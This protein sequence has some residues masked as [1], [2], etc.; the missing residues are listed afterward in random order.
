MMSVLAGAT[1]RPVDL[2]DLRCVG[3]PLLGEI[4][5]HGKRLFE[6]D[7]QSYAELMRRHLFD[8]A[9]FRPYRDRIL[10]ERRAK[11]IDD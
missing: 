2:I 4:L 8:A 6:R 3:E 5:K 10:A 1:G 7:E 9:D 11:W